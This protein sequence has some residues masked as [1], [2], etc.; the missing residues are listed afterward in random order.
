MNYVLPTRTTKIEENV[1]KDLCQIKYY[2]D[3]SR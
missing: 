3:W 1:Y 2:W